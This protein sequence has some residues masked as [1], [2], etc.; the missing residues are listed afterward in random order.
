MLE[1]PP[2][3]NTHLNGEESSL[4]TNWSLEERYTYTTKTVNEG[5]HG[6]G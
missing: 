5:L 1:S 4:K 3:M 2:L 6:V